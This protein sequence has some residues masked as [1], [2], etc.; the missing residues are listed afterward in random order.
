MAEA[1]LVVNEPRVKARAR[2]APLMLADIDFESFT[3]AVCV[4]TEARTPGQSKPC[5]R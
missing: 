5:C 3:S 4:T 2:L 1:R